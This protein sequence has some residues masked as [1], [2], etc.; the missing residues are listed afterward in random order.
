MTCFRPVLEG[1]LLLMKKGLSSSSC[2]DEAHT[3]C[4]EPPSHGGSDKEAVTERARI[5]PWRKSLQSLFTSLN[6]CF[7]K[8][9]L[10]YCSFK[11]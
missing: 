7:V 3:C 8:Y 10:P 6:I 2:M 4:L 11:C 1:K 9:Q 5:E